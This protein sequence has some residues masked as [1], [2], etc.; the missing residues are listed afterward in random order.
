MIRETWSVVIFRL[1]S[2]GHGEHWVLET[3]ACTR[4]ELC[5]RTATL[6]L[7]VENFII[8][9]NGGHTILR[10]AS[11][12]SERGQHVLGPSFAGVERHEIRL[13]K[14]GGRQRRRARNDQCCHLE[15]G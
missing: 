8:D 6:P 2:T 11:A 7:A 3:G 10:W 1:E 14:L 4:A 5:G 13:G 15:V 9:A 12:L